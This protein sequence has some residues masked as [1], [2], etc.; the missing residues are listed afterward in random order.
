VKA[1][2]QARPNRKDRRATSTG[3]DVRQDYLQ[4]IM[5]VRPSLKAEPAS[6]VRRVVALVYRLRDRKY[7]HYASDGSISIPYEELDDV[8]GRGKF[9]AFNQR[10]RLLVVVDAA[11]QQGKTRKYAFHPDIVE[12]Q[13]SYHDQYRSATAPLT[14]LIQGN[15][16]TRHTLP[17]AIVSKDSS[18]NTA[19]VWGSAGVQVTVPVNLE[20]LGRAR[21]HWR[22]DAL[23]FE[24]ATPEALERT[25]LA[26]LAERLIADAHT[27]IAG[28]GLL[29][30]QYRESPSGRLYGISGV[31]NGLH[32]QNVN[33]LVRFAALHDMWDYDIGNCHFAMFKHLANS[34]GYA[35]PTV[36]DYLTH[37]RAIRESL[38]VVVGC[39]IDQLKDCFL[40]MLN[41]AGLYGKDIKAIPDI[42]GRG[43]V[44]FHKFTHHEWIRALR[45]ELDK[46]G[47]VV[48]AGWPNKNRGML[49]NAAGKAIPRDTS[50]GQKIAHLAQ[51]LEALALRAMIGAMPDVSMLALLQHDGFTSRTKLDP[52]ALQAAVARETGIEVTVEERL[53]QARSERASSPNCP[54]R[55]PDAYSASS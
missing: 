18:G 41:G 26:D 11:F 35:C 5:V 25:Q 6:R 50:K 46:G 28:R 43:S 23:R 16:R 27:K 53:L 45:R 12:M 3:P 7:Q 33:R 31:M 4:A 10:H 38:R 37:K 21:D 24:F 32:L 51:G 39:D 34:H 9:D 40:A 47:D 15:G 19:K 44:A 17:S 55:L 20:Q 14:E 8:F 2:K 30:L 13:Q 1:R 52:A 54:T 42:L 29:V 49:I 22:E 48:L 36:D